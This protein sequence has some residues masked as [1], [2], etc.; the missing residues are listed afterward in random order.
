MNIQEKL[1][2][3]NNSNY[4]FPA[5]AVIFSS[6]FVWGAFLY[7]RQEQ[8]IALPPGSIQKLHPSIAKPVTQEELAQNVAT[9]SLSDITT[10]DEELIKEKT[11]LNRKMITPK[12]EEDVKR[13]KEIV[14]AKGGEVIETNQSTIVVELPEETAEEINQDLQAEEIAQEIEV[15]HPI[16]VLAETDLWNLAK[17]D[18]PRAWEKTK[19]SGIKVGVIDTGVDYNHPEF[20]GRFVGGYD[21]VNEDDDPFDGHGHGT[22]VAGIIASA[23]NNSGV[24]GVSPEVSLYAYK[25]IADNGVGYTSDLVESLDSAIRDGIQTVNISIGTDQASSTLENKLNQAVNQGM[26]IVAAAGNTGGGAVL[27]PAAYDSVISV[28]ATDENDQFASFSSLGAEISAP[29]VNILSTTPG[30]GYTTL[31]GTSMA[32]PHVTATTALLIANGTSAVRQ[33]LYDSTLDLGSEGP[34]GIFGYGLVQTGE[35][36]VPTEPSPTPEAPSP[37]PTLEPSPIP[38]PSPSLIA[39]PS[40]TP[41]VS[42]TPS[43]SPSVSPI[44]SPKIEKDDSTKSAKPVIERRTATSSSWLK[45]FFERRRLESEAKKRESKKLE[46]ENQGKDEEHRDES[47]YAKSENA[48]KDSYEETDS[49]TGDPVQKTVRTI[50]KAISEIVKNRV[51]NVQKEVVKPSP[52]PT[53]KPSPSPEIEE[54]KDESD[55]E[56]DDNEDEDDDDDKEESRNSNYRDDDRPSSSRRGSVRGISTEESLEDFIFNLVWDLLKII[57]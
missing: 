15:D 16:F 37:T 19:G 44:A 51:N 28:A 30:G 20:A 24:A 33:T 12:S 48:F 27:Y 6:V 21:N 40:A 1:P 29:G 38:S 53:P 17:V 41:I 56:D 13:I 49:Q 45:E 9:Y 11:N 54:H 18:A 47:S 55:D 10:V 42:A 34:D 43:A 2:L 4:L 23:L 22:H 32:A 36:I 14:E 8:R 31:S 35:S 39:S 52:T 25:A 57:I 46:E 3:K 5:L 50:F 7:S 26:V